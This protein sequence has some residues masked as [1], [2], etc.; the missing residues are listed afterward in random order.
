MAL[1]APIYLSQVPSGNVVLGPWPPPQHP[2][3][4]VQT[5][6]GRKACCRRRKEW[7]RHRCFFR[8]KQA[9]LENLTDRRCWPMRPRLHLAGA[10]RRPTAIPCM[11]PS[12]LAL[13][14]PFSSP[15]F[16][17]Q[18]DASARSARYLL[19]VRHAFFCLSSPLA[20]LSLST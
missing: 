2:P 14:G 4:A 3:R 8:G 11:N 12:Y 10:T 13:G 6:A 15:L 16:Q 20:T 18:R 5:P 1:F 17:P 7:E 19:A 9:S